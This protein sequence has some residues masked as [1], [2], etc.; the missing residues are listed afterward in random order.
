[1][2]DI[3][4]AIASPIEVNAL[5]VSEFQILES[6][7]PLSSPYPDLPTATAME[8]ETASMY[9]SDQPFQSQDKDSNAGTSTDG[10]LVTEVRIVPHQ[11]ASRG[12]DLVGAGVEL[13]DRGRR[14]ANHIASERVR[15]EEAALQQGN[16][17]NSLYSA[18]FQKSAASSV[19][20]TPE[21]HSRANKVGAQRAHDEVSGVNKS[22]YFGGGK[23]AQKEA[24][25]VVRVEVPKGAYEGTLLSVEL[26]PDEL[27]GRKDLLQRVSVAVPAGCPPG[28][29]IEATVCY[30]TANEAA[31]LAK[32]ARLRLEA[33]QKLKAE[34]EEYA[35]KPDT[36]K[37]YQY[38]TQQ[39]E[40][41]DYV[42]GG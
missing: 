29:I 22:A 15:E 11:S 2:A 1:M 5:S 14:V 27:T 36:E 28:T 10:P 6:I 24:R 35:H 25:C 23:K 42:Y 21:A 9:Q 17:K 3:P 16:Q 20:Q 40:E 31:V 38:T 13:D 41:E 7:N 39:A 37:E 18:G 8:A 33:E 34:A 32:M 4:V 12:A 19:D 26:P 30:R